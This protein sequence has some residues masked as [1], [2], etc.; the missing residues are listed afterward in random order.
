MLTRW[1]P[2]AP[3]LNVRG[4]LDSLKRTKFVDTYIDAFNSI[5]SNAVDNPIVGGEACYFFWKGLKNSNR[6]QLMK[7]SS[8]EG[9]GEFIDVSE[10]TTRAKALLLDAHLQ[11]STDVYAHVNVLL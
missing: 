3:G 11:R 5:V 10:L 2:V 7:N 8:N 1:A 9:F 6:S 4:R